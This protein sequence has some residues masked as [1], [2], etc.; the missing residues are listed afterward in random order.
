MP[1]GADLGALMDAIA[2]TPSR[3]CLPINLPAADGSRVIDCFF[4]PDNAAATAFS[5]PRPR[6]TRSST[7]SSSSTRR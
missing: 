5:S 2:A 7:R 6:T 3:E 1:S 4:A